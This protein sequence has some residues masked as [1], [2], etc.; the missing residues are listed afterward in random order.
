MCIAAMLGFL[1]A[2]ILKIPVAW[3]SAAFKTYA[4]SSIGIFGGLTLTYIAAQYVPSGLISVVFALSPLL[5]NLLTAGIV[6]KSDFTARKWL[7]FTLSF[8]GLGIICID[9]WV[10]NEGGWIGL[11]LLLLAVTLYSLSGV[12]VQK[13]KLS[14]HPLGK[15]VGTLLFSTPLFLT[16]WFF[17]DGNIP[18]FDPYTASPWA[19][20]YLAIFGSLIGFACY[21][22]I[23][24]AIGATA[25]TMVTL[26]TPILALVLG[27]IFNN[28][29]LTTQM[30]VGTIVVIYGLLVYYQKASGF[31]INMFRYRGHSEK[32]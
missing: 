9:D 30:I 16:A 26:I 28:E 31:T 29:S 20:L 13:E 18:V 3:S 4:F 22:S 27:N 25:V 8:F 5:T 6:G 11:G 1:V 12:L 10:I 23:V 32:R 2:K 14:A 15:T 19:V 21:F 24:H 7:G 17:L